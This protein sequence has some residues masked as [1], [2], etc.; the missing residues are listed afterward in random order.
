M[1]KPLVCSSIAE[2]RTELQRRG[3]RVGLVPTMGYLHRG[4][5]SLVEA[6]RAENDVT[7]VSIFVNPK[8]FGPREDF[9]R[10]PRDMERD[11]ALLAELG[12]D[13]I[14]APTAEAM[15]PVGHHTHVDV[16]QLGNHLCGRSRPGHFRGV[17]TVVLKLFNIVQPTRA[18]FGQK[19]AQQAVIIKR[20][21]ADLDLQLEVKVLPIIRDTDGLALSSRNVYLAPEERL[22]GL[23]LP[24]ALQYA[25]QLI[26]GGETRAT[27]IHETI[28]HELF[29]S[30]LIEIDYIEIVNLHSLQPQMTIIPD[31][32]L[33]ACAIR[34]GKTRLIDNFILGTI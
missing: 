29:K 19:D 9:S 6:S 25:Q 8:Q 10:Y 11:T 22:A 34:V 5:A 2:L 26:E 1:S 20:M 4:H 17:T 27:M 3:G 18:Y 21:A 28:H 31:Q 7:V 12:T 30:K 33:I 32:T 14:F 24:Q 16:E 15:Y 13:L 23:H